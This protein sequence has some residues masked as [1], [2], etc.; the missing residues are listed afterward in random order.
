MK[1]TAAIFL[2]FILILNIFSV[3]IKAEEKSFDNYKDELYYAVY[4]MHSG[5]ELEKYNISLDTITDYLGYLVNQCP[6]ICYTVTIE[7]GSYIGQTD[8]VRQ[9]NFSYNMDI[10]E[11]T[12]RR[13]YVE[14]TLTPVLNKVDK[15]WSD[16]EK[17]LFVHD[18]IVANFMYD[19]RLYEEPG[20]ENHD[21][22][23][24]LK[25]GKGVCQSYAY[26]YIYM[27]RKLGLECYMI[28]SPP[29]DLDGNGEA[30]IMG[31]GW[32]V[33]KIDGKWYHVDAT[34]DD[35]ILGQS[36]HYDFVGE[37]SH[38]KFLLSDRQVETDLNH[39]GFYVPYVEENIKCDE[40]TGNDL[41]RNSVSSVLKVGEYWYYLDP[42][43]KNGGLLKTKDFKTAERVMEIGFYYE[44][45]DTY[46]WPANE[47]ETIGFPQFY[48]GLFEY[49]EHLFFSDSKN[50]YAFDT[51]HNVINPLPIDRIEGNF[52]FGLNMKGKTITYITSRTNIAEN[53]VEG[54]YSLSRHFII[55]DW[56]VEK[57]PTLTEEGLR[58]KRCYYCGEV[59]EH[60]T[61]PPLSQIIKGDIS[62]DKTVNTSD[63]AILKLY[64]AGA[65]D[66]VGAAADL[67]DN[68][69]VD[70]SDLAILKLYL[71]GATSLG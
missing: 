38:E 46:C 24:F 65:G 1:K 18:Y 9:V 59:V 32:N 58:T 8:K 61:I 49:N 39:Y 28:I 51:H 37:V 57:E 53:V 35:P 34:Y 40:Y 6:E 41:W 68:G 21:I 27:M 2:S 13:K 55:K 60:Q 52:Y 70:T 71:A 14:E 5:V 43:G 16:T 12:K 23:G 17:A 69:K 31:H 29:K 47:E 56:E 66:E 48:T 3:G 64:L 20:Y 63:L 15:N 50:I 67:D 62:G 19:Y 42:K 11:A 44:E 45:A 54:S 30:E 7:G 26:T 33:V 4:N 36:Y 22:Y 10:E 25:D